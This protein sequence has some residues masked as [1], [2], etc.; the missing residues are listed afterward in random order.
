VAD[1]LYFIQRQNAAG[2][3]KLIES[4]RERFAEQDKPEGPGTED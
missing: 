4:V 1:I 3:V 2:L